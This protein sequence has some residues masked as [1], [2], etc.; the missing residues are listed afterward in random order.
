[1]NSL[2][3][4]TN[5]SIIFQFP[6]IFEYSYAQTYSIHRNQCRQYFSK[7]KIFINNGDTFNGKYIIEY[8][9]KTTNNNEIIDLNDDSVNI[10]DTTLLNKVKNNIY[11]TELHKII[12]ETQE[13]LPLTENINIMSII[14]LLTKKQYQEF[15][16]QSSNAMKINYLR[17]KYI[18]LAMFFKPHLMP[19]QQTTIIF[20][21]MI[22]DTSNLKINTSLLNEQFGKGQEH[23]KNCEVIEKNKILTKLM[24][25]GVAIFDITNDSEIELEQARFSFNYIYNELINYSDEEIIKCKENRI[26]RKFILI[27]TV[28]TWVKKTSNDQMYSENEEVHTSI[29]QKGVLER[30]PIAKYQI[31]FEFEK[32]LLKANSSKIKDIFKTYIIGTGIIYG[33]EENAFR[34]VFTNAWHNPKEMY[35]AMLNRTVPVFH[36]DELAKLVCIVSKYEH[37]KN[38]YIL[39]VEQESYGFNNIIKSLCDELCTSQLVLKEDHLIM[40]HYKF[41]SFTWD[42]ICSDLN[43]DSMLDVIIPDYQNL[44]T[45]IISN[46]K[47]LTREFVEVNNLYS[48][49]IIVSGQPTHVS[50]KIAERLAKYYKVKFINIPLLINNY[51]TLLKNDRIKLELKMNDIY[52]NRANIKHT[53]AK[54]TAQFDEWLEQIND[55]LNID[56]Y[57]SNEQNNNEMVDDSNKNLEMINDTFISENEIFTDPSE[58]SLNFNNSKYDN[59][60]QEHDNYKLLT[61]N[62]IDLLESNKE[63]NNIKY[64]IQHLNEKYEK[65]ENN[66]NKNKGRLDNHYLLPL[67]KE[68]LSS[69]SCRNQGYIL[70]IF[71][72]YVEQMEFIFNE[73]IIYPNDIILLSY[74]RIIT[75]NQK[76]C[77]ETCST[78]INKN[79]KCI[80]SNNL[81]KNTEM[82]SNSFEHQSSDI[83]HDQDVSFNNALTRSNIYDISDLF[84][85]E[86]ESIYENTK[87]KCALKSVNYLANYSTNK[88]INVHK[89]NIP[90][91]LAD[92]TISYNL[93]YKFYTDTIISL[94]GRNPFKDIRNETMINGSQITPKQKSSKT[95]MTNRKLKIT[96]NKLNIMKE[97]WKKDITKT[98]MWEKKQEYRKSVKIHNFLIT[99]IFPKLLKEISPIDNRGSQFP[100]K[101][102]NKIKLCNTQMDN[103]LISINNF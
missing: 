71:P 7:N 61:K 41:N 81:D 38:N 102:L 75:D 83:Y 15:L 77:E 95:E 65:Y 36:V 97:Q 46:M 14:G 6:T 91:D 62:K 80:N 59:Y 51:F 40:S 84:K 88:G 101:T 34:Y 63:I 12:N 69:F 96:S 10:L 17:N 93:Q 74:D 21:D 79:S 82:S 13:S 66:F 47:E 89:L 18:Q 45:S 43:I 28:M 55:Q 64:M 1:M 50:S 42:L 53:L 35:I 56:I 22:Q 37:V 98:L 48:L 19:L 9:K 16:D 27:S 78:I 8:F 94:I 4:L 31:I 87:H 30:F 103:S 25:C 11:N 29:T 39:A 60:F 24:Q 90:L 99:N 32:L 52:K 54:L 3:I 73:D 58:N 72:L 67:I 33:H 92:E 26:V 44:Q 57:S 86:T 70:D 49:K 20:K 100:E 2:N 68:S 23:L 76:C 85:N 5:E